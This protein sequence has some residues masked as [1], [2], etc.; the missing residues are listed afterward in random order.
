MHSNGGRSLGPEAVSPAAGES[1]RVGYSAA[2]V[3]RRSFGGTGVIA[4]A[5][6]EKLRI[7]STIGYSALG[8]SF[9]TVASCRWSPRSVGAQQNTSRQGTKPR[10][11]FARPC[12]KYDGKAK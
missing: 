11:C 7:D 2:L 8:S 6:G 5:T 9:A 10:R 4:G 1:R 3:H 12:G